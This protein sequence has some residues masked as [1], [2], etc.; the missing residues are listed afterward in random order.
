LSKAGRTHERKIGSRAGGV[1]WAARRLWARRWA[2]ATLAL[3]VSGCKAR[4][5]SAG[6]ARLTS[7]AGAVAVPAP[8]AKREAVAPSSRS[9]ASAQSASTAASPA[10]IGA[11]TL[12][13]PPWPDGVRKLQLTWAVYPAVTDRAVPGRRIELVVRAGAVARRFAVEVNSSIVYSISMQRHCQEPHYGG[14][15]VAE[16]YM[17]GGGN[18]VLAVEREGNELTLVE[19]QSA[20]GLCEPDPCPV[21][22]TTLVRIPVPAGVELEERFHYVEGPGREYDEHCE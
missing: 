10:P 17:N 21:H 7:S 1:S 11:P 4:S 2:V 6:P 14:R 22:A 3:C 9:S 15:R 13:A 20:D 19:Q 12:D 8:P 16:L 5:S 18:E